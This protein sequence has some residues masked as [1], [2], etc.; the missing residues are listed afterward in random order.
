MDIR[1]GLA[2]LGTFE[3]TFSVIKGGNIVQHPESV[4]ICD[5][6][7]SDSLYNDR[8]YLDVEISI[9]IAVS[10]NS[11]GKDS[12][13]LELTYMTVGTGKRRGVTRVRTSQTMGALMDWLKTDEKLRMTLAE[14]VAGYEQRNEFS[15]PIKTSLHEL[16]GKFTKLGSIVLRDNRKKNDL[17]QEFRENPSW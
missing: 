14:G 4:T 10:C 16:S 7:F 1:S 9:K 17:L 12:F 5:C 6:V 11:E 13:V 15:E 2:P 8:R 3:R